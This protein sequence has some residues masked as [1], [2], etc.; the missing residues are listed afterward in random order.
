VAT[1]AI[2]ARLFGDESV[3]GSW[4][5][6]RAEVERQ[7]RQSVAQIQAGEVSD[8]IYDA[9]NV[10]RKIRREAI[11]LAHDCGFTSLTGL[12]LNP[13][14]ATCLERNVARDRQ[15]P[16]SV[17]LAMHRALVGAPPALTEGMDRLVEI[18]GRWL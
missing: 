16:L 11:A 17:I 15:V 6:V 13:A 9:T 2:R 5:K 7:F 12:W 4:L 18:Q 1:D 10:V 14:L 8:V 3:Q